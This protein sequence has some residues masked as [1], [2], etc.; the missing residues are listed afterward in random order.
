MLRAKPA[1]LMTSYHTKDFVE[2]KD[3]RSIGQRYIQ[4]YIMRGR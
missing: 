3:G 4:M 1:L 2:E